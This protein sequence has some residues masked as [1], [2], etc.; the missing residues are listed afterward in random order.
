MKKLILLGQQDAVVRNKISAFL[1]KNGYDVHAAESGRE[2]TDGV[3]KYMPD[4]VICDT[5]FGE[6]GGFELI[7][8]L[9][10]TNIA[11]IAIGQSASEEDKV[12]AL[13]CGADDYVV[14]P[15]MK[16]EFLARMRALIRRS[17]INN[18]MEE[19]YRSGE[20]EIDFRKR[21][22]KKSGVEVRLTPVEYRLVE[23]LA[24]HRSCVL[25]YEYLLK[26]IWG[27][28]A[29]ADNKILRVNMTNIRRKIETDTKNPE[30]IFTENGIGY[31]MK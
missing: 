8:E 2:L 3:A 27:P 30:Y 14:R 4:V 5:G 1:E 29:P 22:V 7:E 11:I 21:T 17:V 28:Y 23:L 12:R 15:F 6:N 20:L 31:K 26:R 24:I 19:G 16:K 13:D 18:T 25:T 10:E 9:R